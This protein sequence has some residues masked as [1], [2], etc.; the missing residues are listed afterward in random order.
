MAYARIQN[1]VVVEICN[2]P[3]GFTIDQCF[4]PSLVAQMVPCGDDIQAGWAYADGVFTAPAVIE[5]APAE[6]APAEP[7]EPAQPDVSPILDTPD[8]TPA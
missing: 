8:A 6:P 7:T 1:H 2:P 3:I 4:H 5:P